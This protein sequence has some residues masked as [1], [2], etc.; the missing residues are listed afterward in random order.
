[1][2]HDDNVKRQHETV[3]HMTWTRNVHTKSCSSTDAEMQYTVSR[4]MGG[5]WLL[6]SKGKLVKPCDYVPS[7]FS[8]IVQELSRDV[9]GSDKDE[10]VSK[11]LHSSGPDTSQYAFAN[12]GVQATAASIDWRKAGEEINHHGWQP[13][14][15]TGFM[16]MANV[17]GEFFY[18]MDE[19]IQI[20]PMRA[21]TQLVDE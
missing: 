6:Y 1:M 3:A 15:M 18:R 5:K 11:P 13:A 19:R 2:K 12:V 16:W 4:T 14:L 10:R 8:V 20:S 21:P 9:S 17:T 7:D